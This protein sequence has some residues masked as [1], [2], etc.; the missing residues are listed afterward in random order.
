MSRRDEGESVFTADGQ[1]WRLRFDMNAMADF[2]EETG[3]ADNSLPDLIDYI[4][5]GKL[6]VPE[7]RKLVWVLL[8]EHHPDVTE[9][10]AGRLAFAAM[11][12]LEGAMTSAL[13]QNGDGEDGGADEPEKPK[14]AT[15]RA[16]K[17]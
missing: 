8:R 7:T 17:S 10:Q 11:Q 9:R 16:A 13:P 12:A 1:D 3:R 14:A 6:T 4:G 5:S 15:R 2:A